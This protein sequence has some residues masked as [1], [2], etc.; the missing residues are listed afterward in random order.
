MVLLDEPKWRHH[1]AGSA[2]AAGGSGVKS[3]TP[4]AGLGHLQPPLRF[5][6]FDLVDEGLCRACRD[7]VPRRAGWSP[8]RSQR[9]GEKRRQPASS[10]WRC[11]ADLRGNRRQRRS[12]R[13]VELRREQAA[14]GGQRLRYNAPPNCASELS[15]NYRQK[16]AAEEEQRPPNRRFAPP[17]LLRGASPRRDRD[18][19]ACRPASEGEREKLRLD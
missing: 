12:I 18:I 19:V 5:L 13:Q 10:G 17:L 11:A 15:R 1:P 7:P 4:R 2:G 14:R 6:P 8:A 9:N 3:R 16:L